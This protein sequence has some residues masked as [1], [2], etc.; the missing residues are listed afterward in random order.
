MKRIESTFIL[1]VLFSE[2]LGPLLA[3]ARIWIRNKHHVRWFPQGITALHALV[4]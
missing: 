2:K 3:N 4:I 1:V